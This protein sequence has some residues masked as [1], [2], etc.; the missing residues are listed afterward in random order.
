MCIRPIKQ[1][2]I[3]LLAPAVPV[4][5]PVDGLIKTDDLI[6]D[7]AVEFPI[8]DAPALG[9]KYHLRLNGKSVGIEETLSTLPTPGTTLT[10]AIPVD[11]ELKADGT[12]QVE[13]GLTT[14]PGSEYIV[15]PAVMIIVDRTP[16]GTHQ[17][18][19]MEFPDE[20][21]DGLTLEELSLMGDALPGRIFGYSGLKRGDLIK[22]Y[23]LSLIHK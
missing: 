1:E 23:W 7:I 4:A 16:A 14:F 12:Y 3:D 18:G 21:K 22:T 13:Y 15:S 9:D 5:D 2:P 11:G 6:S 17:L 19:Y 8:W 10:L 20:A